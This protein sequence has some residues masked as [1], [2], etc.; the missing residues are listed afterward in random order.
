MKRFIALIILLLI[1]SLVYAANMSCTPAVSGGKIG[2][3]TITIVSDS[4]AGTASCTVYG[5]EGYVT[6][7]VTVPGSTA[8]T[9]A[10][11]FTLSDSDGVDI[12]GAKGTNGGSATVSNQIM[13][14]IGADP[15]PPVVSG[16]LALACTNMGN[17]RMR[18]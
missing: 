18:R 1:P 5:I 7:V 11:D 15:F 3:I 13:P 12:M 8:P 4:A 14:Y 2:K 9:D 6:R 16:S 10:W 17:A